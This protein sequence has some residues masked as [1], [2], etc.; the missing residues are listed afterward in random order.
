MI[1]TNW[2]LF[3]LCDGV[4]LQMATVA[5]LNFSDKQKI[6]NDAG[7]RIS[8][9]KTLGIGSMIKPAGGDRVRLWLIGD[10]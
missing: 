9:E 1:A 7:I 8:S 2:M 3:W 10:C 5:H 4:C 6:C